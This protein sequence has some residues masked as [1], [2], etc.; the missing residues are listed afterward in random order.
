MANR[1]SVFGA[2]LTGTKNGSPYIAK[3]T[4]Y[5]V[6]ATDAVAI[7]VGDFVK[8]TG[9]GADNEI[10]ESLPVVAQAEGTE[11]TPDTKLLGVVVGFAPNSSYLNQVYRTASTLRTVYV[12]DDPY[13][14]FE[15]QASSDAA[16]TGADYGANADFVVGTAS[17]V[18]GTS[19]IE[20]DQTS[21][22]SST[23]QLRIL[24]LVKRPDNEL[25]LHAKLR[26][27]INE[28]AFK[29]TAGV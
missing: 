4:Q 25:G 9:E 6:P 8:L 12:C 22:T 15:I 5:V 23:A 2:R 11:G 10:G 16:I 28:H 7:Y 24:G 21:I 18:F 1:D 19:G 20:L 17:T 27:M 13:A 3:I 14:E 29:Q 26:C